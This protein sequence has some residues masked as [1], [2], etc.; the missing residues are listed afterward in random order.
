MQAIHADA[1]RVWP[2]TRARGN[3]TVAMEESV[4]NLLFGAQFRLTFMVMD[5]A[6]E[7]RKLNKLWRGMHVLAEKARALFAMS[8]TP[9][10]HTPE[11]RVTFFW[12]AVV[13]M[14]SLTLIV[15]HP[16]SRQPGAADRLARLRQG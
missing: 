11:V 5:E 2:R 3:V 4:E 15:V 9:V 8:A 10:E 1:A 13:P 6:H 7:A 16:G 12:M 14:M